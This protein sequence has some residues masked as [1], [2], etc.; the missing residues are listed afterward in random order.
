MVATY[1][2]T[3]IHNMIFV[4]QVCTRGR[5]NMFFISQVSGLV[6]NFNIRIFSDTIN[7]VN[8]K[9]CI[10]VLLIELYLFIPLSVTLTIFQG[11]RNVELKMLCS[12]SNKLK[13]VGL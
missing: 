1:I 4:T 3:I 2:K 7:V 9:L 13:L 12:Y 11:H 10:M 8:I 6:E 5:Y